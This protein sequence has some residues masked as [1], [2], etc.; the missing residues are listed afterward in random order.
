MYYIYEPYVQCVHMD[1][2]LTP[3]NYMIQIIIAQYTIYYYRLPKL[4]KKHINIKNRAKICIVANKSNHLCHSKA[5]QSWVVF[6]SVK[7]V[8][9]ISSNFNCYCLLITLTRYQIHPLTCLSSQKLS[10]R[11]L[12][13]VI[14]S[15]KLISWH[16]MNRL[17]INAC[18]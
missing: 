2:L 13:Y 17:V 4:K 18:P 11:N 12:L 1:T 6:E 10:S 3:V 9:R 15:S 8:Y 14:Q 5:S 16:Y 7:F